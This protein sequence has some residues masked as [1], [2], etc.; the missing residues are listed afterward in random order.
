MEIKKVKLEFPEDSN[1]ILGHS[2][3]IKTVED[4]YEIM[5]TSIPGAKF[6]FAFSEASQKRLVRK[7]GTDKKL[8]EVASENIKNLKSGH[9]FIIIMRDA[10]PINVL[11]QLKQCMEVVNIHCATANPVEVI[12]AE[13]EQGCGILGVVDGFSPKGV[14]SDKDIKERKKFLRKIGYKR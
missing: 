11:N 14:E 3:F 13:T 7:D 2:H 10:F 9:T 6:G 4:I 5:V 12:L 1:I 8:I